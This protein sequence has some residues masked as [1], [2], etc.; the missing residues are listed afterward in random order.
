M[1]EVFKE[2]ANELATRSDSS[3]VAIELLDNVYPQ[4]TPRADMARKMAAN[5]TNSEKRVFVKGFEGY[6]QD[7]PINNT[8]EYDFKNVNTATKIVI[9]ISRY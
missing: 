2:R 3:G 8:S 4:I 1:T 6:S 7:G 9:I 5:A